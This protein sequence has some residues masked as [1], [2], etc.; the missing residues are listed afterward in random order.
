MSNIVSSRQLMYSVVYTLLLTGIVVQIRKD[1][2]YQALW[3]AFC[4][5]VLAVG[6]NV[7]LSPAERD[8]RLV[9]V[10]AVIGVGMVLFGLGTRA[11]PV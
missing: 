7:C 1:D 11:G 8:W 2:F 9:I 10:A 6:W 5:A 3:F 4:A